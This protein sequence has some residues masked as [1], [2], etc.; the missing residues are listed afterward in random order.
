LPPL[1]EAALAITTPRA[2][3][4]YDLLIREYCTADVDH[5]AGLDVASRATLKLPRLTRLLRYRLSA[6]L[7]VS[8][9][10]VVTSDDSDVNIV[11]NRSISRKNTTD[12]LH[13]Q[14]LSSNFPIF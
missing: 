13:K 3:K 6:E 14:I 8:L 4:L 7:D 2:F 11:K 1:C 9:A 12:R 10:A 5:S